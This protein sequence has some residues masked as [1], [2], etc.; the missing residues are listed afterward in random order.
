[1]LFSDFLQFKGNFVDAQNYSK[2]LD[3]AP[4]KRSKQLF[5]FSAAINA[6]FKIVLC[7]LCDRKHCKPKCFLLS[8]SFVIKLSREYL[9]LVLDNIIV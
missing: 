9:F 6:C 5:R 2:D 8:Y 7:L 3:V 1:M 4:L